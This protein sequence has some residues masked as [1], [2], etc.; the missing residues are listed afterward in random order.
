[1]AFF[2]RGWHD[3]ARKRIIATLTGI[4]AMNR[5]RP[6]FAVLL[7]AS[8]AAGSAHAQVAAG[9]NAHAG[10]A[11]VDGRLADI[12]AYAGTYREAFVDEVVRYR[13]APRELVN[14]LL[15]RPGWTPGDVYFACSLALQSGRPCRA[16]ADLRQ[17]DPSQEWAAIARELGV[18]PG[19]AAYSELK[20]GIAASYVR[21]ARPLPADAGAEAAGGTTSAAAP[22]GKA[23]VGGSKDGPRRKH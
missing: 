20:R 9:G 10:D 19:T 7:A 11:W 15:A 12:G 21:W 18:A 14:E 13:R 2:L 23:V 17:R 5:T 3:V 4:A 16:V 6:V 1:V 8:L 22:P